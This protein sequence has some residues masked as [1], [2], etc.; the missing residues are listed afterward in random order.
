MVFLLFLLWMGEE[1][2]SLDEGRVVLYT[3][4]SG[5]TLERKHLIFARAALGRQAL[6]TAMR[7][8]ILKLHTRLELRE[9]VRMGE[10]Q[11]C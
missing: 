2:G 7:A 10:A 6:A 9:H 4:W 8:G 1:V 11:L 3:S 5:R